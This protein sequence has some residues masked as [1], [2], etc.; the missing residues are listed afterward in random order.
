MA[1]K[2]FG[3]SLY[4][5]WL[6]LRPRYWT[7]LLE[8]Q[9]IPPYVSTHDHV[10]ESK[11]TFLDHWY[12]KGSF[13]TFSGCAVWNFTP[14]FRHTEP[15]AYF[16]WALASKITL[17]HGSKATEAWEVD[18]RDHSGSNIPW[19]DYVG[20][21]CLGGAIQRYLECCLRK[22]MLELQHVETNKSGD[23]VVQNAFFIYG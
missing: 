18:P 3:A 7:S 20:S 11:Y 19:I 16:P 10:S 4:Q 22:M 13:G 9:S 2:L 23:L 21:F 8:R 1:D 5:T 17:D 12:F 15:P 6:L 14:V